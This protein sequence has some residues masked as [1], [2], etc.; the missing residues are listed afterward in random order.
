M[1]SV[2]Q[3]LF[4]L[5]LA[6]ESFRLFSRLMTQ[7]NLELQQQALMLI[8]KQLGHIPDSMTADKQSSASAPPQEQKKGTYH[9][10]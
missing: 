10:I 2:F 1:P 4:E 9:L 8:M 5:I 3:G 7:K 6:T